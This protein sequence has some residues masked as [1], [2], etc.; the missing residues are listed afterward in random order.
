MTSFAKRLGIALAISVALNLTLAGFFLGRAFDRR[1]GLGPGRGDAGWFD[2]RAPRDDRLRALFHEHR[3]D[4]RSR[5]QATRAARAAVRSALERDPFDKA[6]LEKSLADLRAET[7]RSQ[8]RLH[9]VLIEAAE[10]GG[11][12]TRGKLAEGFKRRHRG[13]R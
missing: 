13:R 7:S 12:E 8:E 9:Q 2:P 1:S 11:G 4:F 5:R 3:D 10:K 6:A